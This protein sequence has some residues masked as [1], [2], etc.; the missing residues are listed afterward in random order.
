MKIVQKKCSELIQAEYNPRELTEKQYQDLKD[1]LLRFGVVDPVLVN[2][3]EDRKNIIIG[4]HQ[5]KRVW[6]ELGNKTIPCVELE[7]TLDQ[8]KELNVRLNKNTGQFDMEAL[9]NFF[10]QDELLSWGFEEYEFGFSPELD[11]NEFG[12]DFEL[13]E[14]EKEPIQ[15]M[16]FTLADEQVEAIK[17]ALSKVK[18]LEEFKYVETFMNENQNG[19]ALYL[20]IQQWV[21]QKR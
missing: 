21:E 1:S 18:E 4:G 19:N 12:E 2:S 3:H 13:P 16:T 11:E 14:G 20:I 5:R 10:D 17:N 15:Q 6:Q 8:E 7:L 9:A